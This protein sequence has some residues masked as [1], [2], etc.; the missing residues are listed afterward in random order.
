MIDQWYWEWVQVIAEVVMMK[1]AALVW[2]MVGYAV[3][4]S[5]IKVSQIGKGVSLVDAWS[6]CLKVS[7]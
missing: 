7:S 2:L 3:E 4:L 1:S 6:A 5:W